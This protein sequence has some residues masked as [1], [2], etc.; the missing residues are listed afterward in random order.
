VESNIRNTLNATLLGKVMEEVS[1]S[2][3][4]PEDI[5][6]SIMTIICSGAQYYD[7]QQCK[8]RLKRL[9]LKNYPGEYI[10]EQNKDITALCECLDSADMM[11]P[12]D[13]LLMKIVKI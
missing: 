4:G 5:L 11:P 7:A 6:V 8:T 10:V 12:E 2:A 9:S 13:D 3:S 1:D